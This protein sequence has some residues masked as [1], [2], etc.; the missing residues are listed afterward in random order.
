MGINTSGPIFMRVCPQLEPNL[1]VYIGTTKLDNKKLPKR[2]ALI[3]NMCL[4]GNTED[5]Q[6]PSLVRRNL[7]HTR[8]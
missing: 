2:I 6:D 7:T 3:K 4:H 8:N 5:T 1:T